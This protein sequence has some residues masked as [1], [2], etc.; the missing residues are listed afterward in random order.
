MSDPLIAGAVLFSHT[1]GHLVVCGAII[2]PRKPHDGIKDLNAIEAYK[3]L[4]W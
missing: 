4:I 1:T 3:G 2:E